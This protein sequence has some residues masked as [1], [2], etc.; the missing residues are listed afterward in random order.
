MKEININSDNEN[1]RIDKF[2]FKLLPTMGKSFM[3]KMFRKKNITLNGKKISGMEILKNGDTIKVFFS[4]ETYNKF[5]GVVEEVRLVPLPDILIETDHYIVVNKSEGIFSQQDPQ[6]ISVIEQLAY[7][8]KK[9]QKEL[10][11]GVKVGVSNRLDRNTTG[12]IISG[13][14]LPMVQALNYAIR[15]KHTRKLYRSIVIGVIKEKLILKGQLTKES[16]SNRVTISDAGDDYIETIIRPI[17]SNGHYTE[18]EVELVTGKTHQIRA[19]LASINHAII[20]DS[21]YGN[22][23]VNNKLSE[24]YG[25]KHQLLHSYHYTIHIQQTE[26]VI[27]VIAPLSKLYKSIIKGEF[28]E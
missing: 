7:Y 23:T 25:L 12:V 3:Y 20:G 28:S 21:K 13:K 11:T 22:K 15:E 27:D 2:I 24:K 26:E 17:R 14:T 19:H 8:Y 18:V 5:S 10:A 9:N 4:D 16:L 1:Q 6:G